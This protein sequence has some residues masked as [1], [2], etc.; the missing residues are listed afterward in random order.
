METMQ[1]RL[2]QFNDLKIEKKN[3][4]KC[5][6]CFKPFVNNYSLSNHFLIRGYDTGSQFIDEEH[7]KYY[8]KQKTEEELKHKEEVKNRYYSKKCIRCGATHQ[9]DYEHRFQKRCPECEIKY[10]VKIKTPTNLI[11]NGFC[12]VCHSEMIIKAHSNNQVCINC[13]KKEKEEKIRQLLATPLKVRCLHCEKE[14]FYYRKHSRDR[15]ARILCDDCKNDPHPFK[16]DQKYEKVLYLLEKTDL[17]RREIK[18]LLGLEKDFVR[19]AA[20]EKFGLDWYDRRV[21]FIRDRSGP[22]HGKTSRLFFDNLRKDKDK[23]EEFFKNR[24]S[25]PSRLELIF[26]KSLSQLNLSFEANKW[27]SIKIKG[28]YERRELDLKVPLEKTGKKFAIFIDGEAFHGPDAYFKSTSV[29]KECEIT[30]AFSFLGY[31]SIRYSETEVKNGTALNHFLSKYKE[32]KN[33][34]PSYYY[35]NWMTTEEVI[36]YI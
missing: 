24:S 5:P 13:R 29:E 36:K 22:V 7:K 31:L 9:V 27:M 21:L 33:N 2:I 1:D 26:Q 30:K 12:T 35:R 18:N 15:V 11:K 25:I 14:I 10:P 4:V 20:I 6:V 3:S 34:P 16:K 19:E 28:L 8:L 32:F 23:F 17:T